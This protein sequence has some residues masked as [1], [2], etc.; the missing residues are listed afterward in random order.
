MVMSVA[1]PQARGKYS[2]DKIFG[3]NNRANALAD[4]LGTDRVINGTVGSI[5]DEDGNLVMLDVVRQAFK[6][7]SPKDIISYA[8]IQGYP[9]YLEAVIDQCFGASRPDGYIRA[10]ATSG[11]SGVMHH[12]IHNY[13]EIG[14]EILTSD[15]HWGAYGSMC[16][17]NG[18]KLREFELLKDRKF[19]FEDF[20][21][22]VTDLV[23]KQLNTVILMNSP[24]NNPTGFALSGEDWDKVLAFLQEIVTNKEKNIILVPDVAYLDYSGEKSECRRFFKKFGNLPANILVIVAYTL[25]KG[26][27]MYGQ[28]MGAMIGVTSDA[29]V[30]EEFV[31]INQYSN[32]ATW[33]NSNSAA[34]KA[35]IHI[36]E[37]PEKIK[38]LD[39]ERA[40]YFALIKERAELF[41][42]EADA[43]GLVYLPYLSGF[44]ITIPLPGSQAVCD[45]LEK[46]NIF[47]V[48]L[49]KG[50]R[51]AVCSVSKKKIHGLAVKIKTVTDKLGIDR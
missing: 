48:P 28:R 10:C 16:I 46:E 33:S 17:D 4:K 3:A 22:H 2:E 45:E 23:A 9:E 20:K 26:F 29:D 44:F 42:Q 30:A 39:A 18:R 21:A 49:G 14:D 41:M 25:S 5:L 27:T 12:V 15:W 47:L 43:C 7:L 32:R 24:A 11:G 37:D 31:A 19:N 6:E 1:A 36:C 34:M 50:L 8:P 40:N 35:M 38:Q 13:S 51:L